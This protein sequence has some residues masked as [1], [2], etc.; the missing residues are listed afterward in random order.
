MNDY[1][2]REDAVNILCGE[3]LNYK[4]CCSADGEIPVCPLFWKMQNIPAAD[5]V[6][7]KKGEWVEDYNL[8]NDTY[9]FHCSVCGDEEWGTRKQIE[10]THYC[11]NCGADMRPTQNNDSNALD[12]LNDAL[13]KEDK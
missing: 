5:V 1:I 12:A 3:C 9:H 8:I 2:K 6:E 13:N 10:D 11:P 7:R 4:V